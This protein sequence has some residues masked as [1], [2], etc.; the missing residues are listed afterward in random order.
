MSA[1]RLTGLSGRLQ[2][3]R[4]EAPGARRHDGLLTA[5]LAPDRLAEAWRAWGPAAAWHVD[6]TFLIWDETSRRG[7]LSRDRSG[8]TPVL[9]AEHGPRLA[10]AVDPGPLADLL[11]TAPA[12]DPAGIAGWLVDGAPPVGRTLLSGVRRLAPGHHLVL[13]GCAWQEGV[14]WQPAYAEPLRDRTEAVERVRTVLSTVVADAWTPDS[15]L[16]LSGGLDST[17][18]AALSPNPRP[19]VLHGAFP[20]APEVDESAAVDATV[21]TLGL[22]GFRAATVEPRPLAAAVEHTACWRAPLGTPNEPLWAALLARACREG[23]QA[24]LDGEG[25]DS[26]FGPSPFV[27]ADD[28]RAG[29]WR[30]AHQAAVALVGAP[31]AGRA[32]TRFGAIGAIPAGPHHAWRRLRGARR[33]A[34]EWLRPSPARA[35]LAAGSPWAWKRLDGPR[36]WAQRV[37]EL[38]VQLDASGAHDLPRR[39]AWALGLQAHHPLQDPRLVDLALGLEP[40]F[41]HDPVRDRPLARDA[42]AGI[43]PEHVRQRTTK[44]F[45]NAVQERWLLAE[46]PTAATLLGR[47]ALIAEYVD[48]DAVRAWALGDPSRHPG[49][50]LRWPLDSWRVLAL[51]IWLRDQADPSVTRRLI[52]AE[53]AS[54]VT[55]FATIPEKPKVLPA[56]G[57]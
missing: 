37:H 5:G 2:D 52:A 46:R 48:L 14:H 32:L 30:A 49:G 10:F 19:L 54:P 56:Q 26:V 27:I 20:E 12:V 53:V 36:W 18:V 51:E 57:V 47:D 16:L 43:V 28:L 35:L 41:A 21:A 4:L 50:R 23:A 24:V 42:L 45:F 8:A 22:N 15:A 40:A 3:G 13:N 29:R 44:P 34:P 33:L 55:R 11:P 1:V 7:V 17:A 39:R 6:A 25:G 31:L 9:L 38:G